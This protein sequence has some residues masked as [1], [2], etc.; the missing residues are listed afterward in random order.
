MSR[1]KVFARVRP[2][3][4]PS[5]YFTFQEEH[6][7]LK[8]DVPLSAS[9]GLVNNSKSEYIFKFDGLLDMGVSQEKVFDTVAKDAVLRY[10]QERRCHT[11][12]R[13]RHSRERAGT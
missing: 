7:Q 3:K 5:G 2:S 8:F 13:A 6:N 1:I 12:G 9:A 4:R 10:A 11:A